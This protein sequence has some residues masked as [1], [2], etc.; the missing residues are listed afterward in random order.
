MGWLQQ[1]QQQQQ[2]QQQQQRQQ[3]QQQQPSS[4]KSCCIC[5]LPFKSDSDDYRLHLLH[6]MEAYHGKTLCPLC[7]VDCGHFERLVDHFF[8]VHGGVD[9]HI[10]P[11]ASC[12]RGFRTRRMLELHQ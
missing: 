8:I 9:K 12:V 1:Q 2:E 11:H 6:H 3:Q 4:T 5:C 7:R 10:C